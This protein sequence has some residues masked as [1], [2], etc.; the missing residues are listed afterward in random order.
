MS[1]SIDQLGKEI[2]KELNLYTAEITEGMNEVFED[3]ATKGVSITKEQSESAGFENHVYADGWTK[4][5]TK[6]P[7]TGRVTFT[8]HNKKYYRLTH[9]LEK[10]HAL[11]QGGRT[12]AYPHISIAQ[13]KIEEKTMQELKE[14][15]NKNA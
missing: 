8:I 7:T 5:V 12:N 1:I 13:N 11:R 3:M 4:T 10:G 15:I 14:M 9:L 2:A 6:S